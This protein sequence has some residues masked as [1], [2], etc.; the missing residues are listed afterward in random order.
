MGTQAINAQNH[1][2][3]TGHLLRCG[4]LLSTE[5]PRK[6]LHTIDIITFAYLQCASFAIAQ[7]PNEHLS[8][9]SLFHTAPTRCGHFFLTRP[10][11]ALVNGQTISCILTKKIPSWLRHIWKHVPRGGRGCRHELLRM[12]AETLADAVPATGLINDGVQG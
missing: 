3:T 8:T 12:Y 11:D 9:V 6:N 10:N 2:R 4:E 5:R 7:L 1:E